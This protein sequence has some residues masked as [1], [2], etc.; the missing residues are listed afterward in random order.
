MDYF[1][2]LIKVSVD[3]NNNKFWEITVNG[4]SATR[5]WGR[6]GTAGSSK[7]ESLSINQASKLADKKMAEGYVEVKNIENINQSINH[8]NNN[9]LMLKFLKEIS[10]NDN[11][12]FD[13]LKYCLASNIHTILTK[14]NIKFDEDSG[15]FKTP[16]GIITKSAIQEAKELLYDIYNEIQNSPTSISL[17]DKVNKY[18]SLIPQRVGS[19]ID[20]LWLFGDKERYDQ[21]NE[22]LDALLSSLDMIFD[23]K[24]Q[25][26]PTVSKIVNPFDVSIS[27]VED[28]IEINEI[29]KNFKNNIDTSHPSA[30]LKFINAYKLNIANMTKN[31]KF[32][33][34]SKNVKRLW[35]GTRVG[36]LLSIFK[37]GMQIISSKDNVVTG[38]MFG[39]GLY[40][41]DVST[42]ALNYSLGTW[43][44]TGDGG[45][46]IYYALL[47]DVFMGNIYEAN[48]KSSKYPVNGYDST[49]VKKGV[50]GL[51]NNEMIVYKTEQVIPVYLVE[52]KMS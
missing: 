38:R 49:F 19:K 48:D 41:S 52:F 27:K 1:K 12:I 28:D 33:K 10:N 3:D 21:Q 42:K 17:K 46:N 50:K 14:T 47:C 45:K 30:R 40:F 25:I 29:S 39:N 37:N 15:L 34:T 43:N 7:T 4:N 24:E 6:V 35:H 9:D 8:E 11:N 2:R 32:D 5:K 22:I 23:K 13:I 18:L 20:I 51:K 36:N 44:K 31:A 16:L 26:N